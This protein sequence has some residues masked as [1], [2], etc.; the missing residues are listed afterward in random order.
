MEEF[1]LRLLASGCLGVI[2]LEGSVLVYLLFVYGLSVA[3][4]LCSVMAPKKRTKVDA[5]SSSSQ[6][7]FDAKIFASV[8]AYERYQ[9]LSTNVVI[10]DRARV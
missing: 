7:G 9:R 10:Q 1:F 2:C 8:V 5:G 3:I 4:I 6:G